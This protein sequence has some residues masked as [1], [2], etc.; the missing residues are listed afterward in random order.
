MGYTFSH[1][2]FW[3][4]LVVFNLFLDCKVVFSNNS[5]RILFKKNTN[6]NLMH[7]QLKNENSEEDNSDVGSELNSKYITYWLLSSF[8]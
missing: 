2:P 4:A 3:E 8:E 6:V 7:M 1:T 5:I